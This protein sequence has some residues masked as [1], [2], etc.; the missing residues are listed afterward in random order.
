MVAEHRDEPG[1]WLLA[2][3]L[4]QV[5]QDVGNHEKAIE[6]SWDAVRLKIASDG[7]GAGKA[8]GYLRFLR[9]ED[10]DRFDDAWARNVGGEQPTWL[11]YPEIDK[12]RV[13]I[14]LEWIQTPSWT[15]SQA[16]L[17]GNGELILCDEGGATIEHLLD[18]HPADLP[19]LQHRLLLQAA[20]DNGVAAAY[21]ALVVEL[22]KAARRKT[23]VEWLALDGEES[24]TFLEEHADELLHPQCEQELLRVFQAE[25]EE[26][27][28]LFAAG[29]FGLARSEGVEKGL[30]LAAA[31]LPPPSDEDCVGGGD[32]P[33]NLSLARLRAALKAS[34]S[35]P[36][37]Q[38]A[39]AAASADRNEEA[40]TAIDRCRGRASE[41]DR[42]AYLRRLDALVGSGA[43]TEAIALLRER[44]GPAGSGP[45]SEGS[46]A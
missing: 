38:H 16:F 37:F 17:E 35:E 15:D 2:L 33:R 28:F 11:R 36:Q 3:C 32:S 12:R 41:W 26:S 10:R 14:I 20:R 45:L 25:P 8:R 7:D 27:F 6:G 42:R 5:H 18:F 4:A 44:L 46:P 29:L 19:L 39:L 9:V 40:S 23:M 13:D 22:R 21:E 30:A 34:E 31:G 1:G 24:R 43:K